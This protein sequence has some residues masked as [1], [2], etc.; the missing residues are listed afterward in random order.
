MGQHESTNATPASAG[1]DKGT[2]GTVER[3]I[4]LLQFVAER[5]SF[6]VKDAVTALRLPTST[7]H[8]LLLQLAQ[9]G[10]V[11]RESYQGYR[12]SRELYR[13]SG[14]V[15]QR[16]DLHGVAHSHLVELVREFDET[17]SFAVYL[18]STH[19][20]MIV[21]TV[22]TS[23]PLQ[24]RLEPF[25]SWPLTWGSLGRVMLAHLPE[26]DVRE[27]LKG[28]MPSPAT[29]APPPTVESIAG[30]LAQIRE[31]GYYVARNHNVAGA[32]GTSAAVLG[33]GGKLVGAIGMTIPV[34]RYREELQPE[35]SA[36]IRHHAQ[37]L[38]ASLGY[39]HES[40]AP[41]HGRHT[42]APSGR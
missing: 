37:M 15:M 21:E 4:R 23:H 26:E 6:N 20:G 10:L 1:E 25:V 9:M 5:G 29:G 38:S 35:I 28:A 18:P 19:S 17:C 32:V 11:E 13:L 8:R 16:F 34:A 31:V 40:H 42:A 41:A 36:R 3:V 22:L 12:V 24:F 14:L 7:V 33:A 2:P 27:A 39:S 30:E